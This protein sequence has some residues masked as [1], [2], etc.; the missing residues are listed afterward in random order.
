MTLF[1]LNYSRCNLHHYEATMNTKEDIISALL[2]KSETYLSNIVSSKDLPI[3]SSVDIR[4]AGFKCAIVDTNLFPAGFN[5]LDQSQISVY[6][7]YFTNTIQEKHKNVKDILL[8]IESNSRNKWYLENIA[9]LK[10]IL[11]HAGY[12]ITL[13]SF[14]HD[15][16][17][18]CQQQGYVIL[19]SQSEEK[20]KINCLNRSAELVEDQKKNYDLILLNNDLIN[21]IPTFLKNLQIPILPSA[22]L[23]WHTRTKAEHFKCL[24]G[25]INTYC[26]NENCDPWLLSTYVEECHDIDIFKAEAI[27]E[28]CEKAAHILAKTQQ[29]YTEYNITE[30]PF[31]IIKANSGTYGMGVVSFENAEAIK[32][33]NRKTKNKLSKGK[34][35]SVIRSFIIQEGVPT[36]LVSNEKATEPC[37]YYIGKHLAGGFLRLNSIKNKRQNLNSLGMSFEPLQNINL[38]NMHIY[39][40]L[41]KFAITAVT[42]EEHS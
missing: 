31:V 37:L 28:L 11:E 15:F 33:M 25:L 29:K 30:Q 19:T 27:N 10:K 42:K 12:N 17:E 40:Q 20:L 16:P 4:D 39:E 38:T 22:S 26:E 8:I 3:Y 24:H 34:G 32:T 2:T 7:S 1:M 14:L 36:Q 21:G 6:A 35:G 41:G 5:N 23:G 13:S 9:V 18:E